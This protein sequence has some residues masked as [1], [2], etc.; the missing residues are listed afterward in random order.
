M[1]RRIWGLL[2]LSVVGLA[3]VAALF[4]PGGSGTPKSSAHVNTGTAHLDIDMVKD[5]SDWC[6]PVTATANHPIGV[7]YEVAL[8]LTDAEAPPASLNI[9]LLYN[10]LLNSC[11]DVANSGT[12]L[13]DNPDANAGTTYWD[14][15][16]HSLGTVGWDCSAGGTNYPRCDTNT[17]TGAGKGRA[18][19]TC[20]AP[21]A[22]PGDLTL[23]VGAGVSSPIAVLS[24]S[25][26][27]GGVDNL[28]FGIVKVADYDVSTITDCTPV[29]TCVGATDYKGPT[30][31][32]VPTATFTPVTPPTRTPT[33]TPTR[34]PTPTATCTPTPASYTPTPIATATPTALDRA[35]ERIERLTDRACNGPWYKAP[36]CRALQFV[37]ALLESLRSGH[38]SR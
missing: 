19:F 35:I 28:A 24:L 13:D 5:G 36:Q 31:T 12:G 17:E 15:V 32:P 23:P 26:A 29:G 30:P 4:H 34:T 8:C 25:A 7:P 3:L 20:G 2:A 38:G 1:K 6:D 11:T 18:F 10:D 16:G 14:T 33:A 27:A 37:L 22:D 21:S 9:E